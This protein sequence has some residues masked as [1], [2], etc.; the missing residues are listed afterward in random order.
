MIAPFIDPELVWDFRLP[1]VQSINTSGHKYG[2]VYPGVGWIIWRD[3]EAL[4]EDLV[5]K[6]DYL[7]GE[8]STFALNFS[9]PGAQIVAQYFN[10]LRLGLEGYREVQQACRDTAKW[11]ASAISD[12]GPYELLS[13]GDELPVFAFRTKEDAPFSVFT[14]SNALRAHGWLVP[15]YQMPAGMEAIS[16]LRLVIRNGFSRDLARMLL[17]DIVR[18]TN[19]LAEE[20]VATGHTATVADNK[21]HHKARTGFHH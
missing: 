5:F 17:A 13:N 8:M 6:V 20:A 3:T 16:V 1:R 7:G 21:A 19:H 2:L 9:R 11:L 14:V 4:P 18:V 12:I 10:F 15:A